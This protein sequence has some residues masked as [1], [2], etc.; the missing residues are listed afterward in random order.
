LIIGA[1]HEETTIPFRFEASAV[2]FHDAEVRTDRGILRFG[3][4]VSFDGRLALMVVVQ[5]PSGESASLLVSGTLDEP[6]V[7]RADRER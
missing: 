6:V 7:R 5:S 2:H 1:S 4:T 3:G